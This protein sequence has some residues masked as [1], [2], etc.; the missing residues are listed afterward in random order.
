MHLLHKKTKVTPKMQD[1]GRNFCLNKG[2]HQQNQVGAALHPVFAR[3]LLRQILGPLFYN[4][5]VTFSKKLSKI[6]VPSRFKRFRRQIRAQRIEISRNEYRKT[7]G[8]FFGMFYHKI[9]EV[10]KRLAKPGWGRAKRPPPGLL[11]RPFPT[12]FPCF[13]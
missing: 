11:I 13:L 2:P 6:Q 10:Q 12:L 7:P 3:P 9:G 5:G 1:K 8:P 4:F